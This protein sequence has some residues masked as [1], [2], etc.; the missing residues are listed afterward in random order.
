MS[1][2]QRNPR[3]GRSLLGLAAL[4]LLTPPLPAQP[5]KTSAGLFRAGGK[6]VRVEQFGPA[7]AGKHPA[8]VLLHGSDGLEAS[9]ALYRHCARGLAGEGYVV[10]L[11]HYFDRTGTSRTRPGEIRRVQFVPWLDTVREA[12]R[13]AAKR[14]EVDGRRVG[15]V[16]FSLGA[17]LALAA[18]AQEDL[19]VAAVIDLFGGL[20]GELHKDVKRLPPTLIVHG[21]A[22]R[23]VP[24]AEAHALENL[25]RAR[26]LPYEIHIYPG[27]DHLFRTAPFGAEARHARRLSLAFL[28][29]HLK[30]R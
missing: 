27:Q 28:A 2:R 20:P 13:Y 15:L 4:A 17:Y 3:S 16:G 30:G 8:V 7:A 6:A 26:R 19:P 5:I 14:P 18:A 10:L 25:C 1:W 11:V 22:D 12:V 29:R 24:V 9:G 21:D 23:T